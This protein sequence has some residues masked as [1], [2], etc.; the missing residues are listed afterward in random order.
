MI[1]GDYDF[2]VQQNYILF[3]LIFN[4]YHYSYPCNTPMNMYVSIFK[5]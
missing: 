2:H 5:C 1:S 4:P 3:Q